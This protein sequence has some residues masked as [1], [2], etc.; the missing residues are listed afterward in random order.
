MSVVGLARA[1]G[2]AAAADRA[3]SDPGAARVRRESVA[4]SVVRRPR[5]R[6]GS[7]FNVPASARRAIRRHV[8]WDFYPLSLSKNKELLNRPERPSRRLTLAASGSLIGVRPA[9]DGE[10]VVPRPARRTQN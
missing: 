10:A 2:L 7:D 8:S 5:C 4:E 3:G 9:E 6:N 1:A